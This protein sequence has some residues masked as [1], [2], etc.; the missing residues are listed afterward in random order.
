VLCLPI[1]QA[2]FL[3]Q[4]NWLF[5]TKAF[6]RALRQFPES[7]LKRYRRRNEY[8]IGDPEIFQETGEP[9]N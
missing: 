4:T 9:A 1:I 8:E 7:L 2:G 6:F 3:L 5:E